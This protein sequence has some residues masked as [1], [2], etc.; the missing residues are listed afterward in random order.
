MS[1]DEARR[2]AES[3]HLRQVGERPAFR[4]YVS[5]LWQRRSFIWTMA[6]AKRYAKN[7]GQKY[8]QLWAILNPLLLI[9]SY[10][11]VFGFLLN[12]S[13][14]T[15]NFIGYLAV[16]IIV[17]GMTSSTLTSGS[18]A[19]LNNTGLVRAL[20]FPRAVLPISTVITETLEMA[21]GL[22]LLLVIM[23]F[24]GDLP[25]WKWLLLPVA[26]GLQLLIQTGI[27]LILARL[28][29]MSADLW[30][31]IPVAVRLLRYVSGVFFSI[32]AA[33]KNH[34]VLYAIL[35]FQPFALPLTLARQAMMG[36][37]SLDWRHWAAAAAYALVL[38]IAG[39]WIFWRDEAKYGR[40]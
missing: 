34:P 40:G 6:E 32:A 10:L 4:D 20:Q 24:T 25:H 12:A 14:G 26:I 22:V 30:N 36:E 5:D 21:T 9:G 38:P 28:V 33:T 37:F 1:L 39:L 18:R 19:I 27:T 29:N 8:G 31:L 3:H 35:E 23:P 11:F 16:G 17:F 13:G 15:E 7:E 2:Y